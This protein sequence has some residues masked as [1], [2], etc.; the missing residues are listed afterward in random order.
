MRTLIEL[1]SLFVDL[2][3]GRK[4]TPTAETSS[5]H[6]VEIPKP[7]G[8]E[9][10]ESEAVAPVEMP[11]LRERYGAVA[12]IVAAMK[13]KGYEVFEKDDRNFNL[14]IVGIR[15]PNARLDEFDCRLVVFWKYEGEWVS[16]EWKIT[17]FPGSRYLIERLLNPK[18]AAI[19]VPGQYAGVY[20]LDL[21]GGRYRAL[22]QRNGSVNVY[23]DGDRDRVFDLEPASIMRG[24]FGINIHAP[25]TPNSGKA[26]YV[27]ERVYAASAGCQV[28][29]RVADFL[30]F[31]DLCE[32]AAAVF[33]NQFTYTLLTEADLLASDAEPDTTTTAPPLALP[34]TSPSGTWDPQFDTVGVRHK[35]L[36]NVKGDGWNYSLGRDARGHNIFPTFEKGLRAGII[37]LRTYYVKHKKRS[38]AAILARWA[39]RTD[40]IGSLP[41]AEPNAPE[42][43]ANFV[44][45]RIGCGAYAVLDTFNEAGEIVNEDLLFELVAAMAAYEND[46]ALKLPRDIFDGALALV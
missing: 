32:K 43:Y 13:R 44:A 8:S 33:G 7:L 41:G 31:R 28:F 15:N 35:N 24:S 11:P 29:E 4:L 5:A 1:L 2:L 36:L 12:P 25:V 39:P 6:P 45:G 30:K 14:N 34:E 20:R 38:I 27:A 17:T 26:A 42:D 23:R 37:T 40:T 21:H 10:L 19:L 18:G 16:W 46:A 9:P 22:C 3:S